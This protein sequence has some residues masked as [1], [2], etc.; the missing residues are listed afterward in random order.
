MKSAVTAL[1]L[2]LVS[3]SGPGTFTFEAS[4]TPVKKGAYVTLAGADTVGASVEFWFRADGT[5]SW[6]R[7][8]TTP[9]RHGRYS[10][11][12]AQT[13]SGTWKAAP[14]CSCG[15]PARTGHVAVEGVQLP[16]IV[17][18]TGGDAV[19][20][21]A[22]S[23]DPTVD[24]GAYFTA[25]HWTS[26]SMTTGE[27]TAIEH[28]N[29]CVPYCAAGHYHTHARHLTFSDVKSLRGAPA[30]TE[31]HVRETHD[32]WTLWTDYAAKAAGVVAFP[33]RPQG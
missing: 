32:T 10:L 16:G 2:L 28:D 22:T 4:P 13:R 31:V 1:A 21:D 25:L 3:A 27:A 9:A 18:T 30:Y 17:T 14:A 12:L 5:E 19:D 6:T 20:F 26:R 23:F 8:T 15:V 24:G 33:G 7:Q 11:R 29:D